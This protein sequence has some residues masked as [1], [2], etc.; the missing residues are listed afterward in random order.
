MNEPAEPLIR[1]I[2]KCSTQ[3]DRSGTLSGHFHR[4]GCGPGGGACAF[5]KSFYL[6]F[7]VGLHVATAI[8]PVI[9]LRSDWVRIIRGFFTSIRD[10]Q[11]DT[12]DQKMAWLLVL[13]TVPVGIVG[14]L[15]EHGLRTLFAKPRS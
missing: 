4:P 12:P 3:G 13:S 8:A 2:A 5:D 6:T 9:F 14:L 10:R 7:F 11:V 15:F 1:K